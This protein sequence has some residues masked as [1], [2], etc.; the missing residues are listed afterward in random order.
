MGNHP[1]V[2]LMVIS[3]ERSHFV[4]DVKGLY[5]KNWWSVSP[6]EPRGNLY[7]IFAFVPPGQP[8]QFFILSES[9]VN[10]AIAEESSAARVRAAAKGGVSK[11]DQFPGVSWSA[12]AAHKGKWCKLPDWISN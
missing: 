6:K 7:Y 2:D 11:F 4:I 3:P 5:K 8:N 1:S 12:A 10:A 9:E